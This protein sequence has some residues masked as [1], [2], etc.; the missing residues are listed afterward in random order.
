[1]WQPPED[2]ETARELD[3]C[4]RQVELGA[5]RVGL[6]A[7]QNSISPE[8]ELPGTAEAFGEPLKRLDGFGRRVEL[9]T[10]GVGLFP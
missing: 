3:G 10:P 6:R 9:G 5:P 2:L 1:M 4:G 8:T 7:I